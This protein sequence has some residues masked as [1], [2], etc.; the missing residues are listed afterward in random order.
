MEFHVGHRLAK[1]VK[2]L[3]AVKCCAMRQRLKEMV[4]E[5][6]VKYPKSC[7]GETELIADKLNC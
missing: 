4:G 5:G 2:V 6:V 1:C 7:A 3:S